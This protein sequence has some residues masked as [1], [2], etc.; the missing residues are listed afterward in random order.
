[1]SAVFNNLVV[2]DQYIK[3]NSLSTIRPE[4]A[5]SWAWSDDGKDLIFKLRHGVKCHDGKPF[6]AADVKSRRRCQ[7]LRSRTLATV[8][9]DRCPLPSLRSIRQGGTTGRARPP[10]AR[11][12]TRPGR[13]F[14]EP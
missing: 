4:P 13:I 2:Y 12:G 14:A 8:L 1:M 7:A 5:K 6:T 3:Q 10:K 9:E 11:R